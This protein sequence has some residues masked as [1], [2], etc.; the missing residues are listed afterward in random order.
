MLGKMTSKEIKKRIAEI[1]MLLD[2][3]ITDK[4]FDLLEGEAKHLTK[5]L[6]ETEQKERMMSARHI[7]PN[8]W[9]QSFLHSFSCGT[10]KIT[11]KQS[12]C[13]RRINNGKPFICG[14]RRYE[15]TGPNYKTGFGML[16]VNTI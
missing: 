16:V 2:S 3:N 8:E 9:V 6:G 14:G 11:N 10:Y 4:E 15:F 1:D 13:F 7:H 12:E 5:I